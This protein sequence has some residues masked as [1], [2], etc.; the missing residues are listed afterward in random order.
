M[1][2]LLLL[3]RVDDRLRGAEAVH[4]DGDAAIDG[5]LRQ[6]GAD[7]VRRHA[8]VER[9][10]GVG[11]ELF[12]LAQ[13]RDHAEV[14]DRALARGERVVAPRLAPAVLRDDALEVAVEV[15]EVR[16][17]LVDIF[18]ARDLAAHLHAG[19][20]NL[21][22]H[23]RPPGC[24]VFRRSAFPALHQLGLDAELG[25]RLVVADRMDVHGRVAARP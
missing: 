22:I 6:H 25:H 19:V 13:R 14:E 8:V 9:A 12:H 23:G 24:L 7:L 5:D 1:E 10:A 21:L 4:A 15:G 17:R 18:I 11:L 2:S 20:V 3:V 16:H